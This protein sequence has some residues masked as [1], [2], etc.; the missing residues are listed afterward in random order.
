MADTGSPRYLILRSLAGC[1]EWIGRYHSLSEIIWR[2]YSSSLSSLCNS[3]TVLFKFPIEV[4]QH[5]IT[6]MW[7]SINFLRRSFQPDCWLKI[8]NVWTSFFENC[9]H[10]WSVFF[11]S[12]SIF[13]RVIESTFLIWSS[14]LYLKF[15]KYRCFLKNREKS[16]RGFCP[17]RLCGVRQSLTKP[18]VQGNVCKNPLSAP[19]N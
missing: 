14:M 7:A 15:L 3:F 16:I 10:D 11:A 5:F 9:C 2:S 6:L 4:A 8:A 17:H 19:S 13:S 12:F 1:P 18:W